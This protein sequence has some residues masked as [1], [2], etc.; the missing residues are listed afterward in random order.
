[1]ARILELGNQQKEHDLPK[2]WPIKDWALPNKTKW[3]F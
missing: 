2:R 1:M 3:Q